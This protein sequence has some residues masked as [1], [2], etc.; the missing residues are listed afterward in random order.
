M[1][2]VRNPLRRQDA[3]HALVGVTVGR[4][5]Y[6][7]LCYGRVS[8]DAYAG[9]GCAGRKNAIRGKDDR[10]KDVVPLFKS[11]SPLS[12]STKILRDKES[13]GN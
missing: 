10:G 8:V 6:S 13:N 9:R 2:S 12:I 3:L 7:H 1:F 11:L 4:D 5:R